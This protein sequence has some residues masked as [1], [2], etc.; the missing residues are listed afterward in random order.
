MRRKLTGVSIC[1]AAL[2]F[3]WG[4]AGCGGGDGGGGAKK[5]T[6]PVVSEGSGGGK[7][8]AEEPK[9]EGDKAAAPA[10]A[11]EGWGTIKGQI[12]WGGEVPEVQYYIKKGDQNAKDAHV[13][14]VEGVVKEDLVI[15]KE[16]KGLKWVVIYLGGTP[17]IHP[18]LEKAEG[19]AE[20]GQEHCHFKP[21]VLAM[22]AGQKF[23]VSSNDPVAHNTKG[24]G[25][26]NSFNPIVPPA[27]PGEK[28]SL[29]PIDLAP[30]K[31]PIVISC[32]IH[33][34]FMFAWVAVFDH[35]YYAVTDED[36]NFEIK[37][38]PAGVQKLVIWHEKGYGEGLGKG[39]EITVKAG[40][41]VDLGPITY[42]P[43]K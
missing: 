28:K 15:N 32:S 21:H 22:R 23:V 13:C 38:A 14:A 27:A 4:L 11:E 30:E 1:L 29:D 41:T 31:K 35:P 3:V 10:G 2:P 7:P 20:L 17:K 43:P 36:G 16:N 37:M 39:K 26:Q 18:D 24:D 25:F 19:E 6:P 9:P 12:V 40:E 42:N 33:T 34:G 5:T 8:T